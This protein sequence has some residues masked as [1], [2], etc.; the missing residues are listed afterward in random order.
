MEMSNVLKEFYLARFMD[1]YLTRAVFG[2]GRSLEFPFQFLLNLSS[3]FPA[4]FYLVLFRET[5]VSSCCTLIFD[6]AGFFVKYS[7]GTEEVL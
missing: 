5:S 6:L 4:A 7:C 1:Y 3:I 2:S